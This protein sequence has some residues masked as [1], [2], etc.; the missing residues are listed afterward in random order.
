MSERLT[1]EQLRA[2]LDREPPTPHN[3]HCPVRDGRPCTCRGVQGQWRDFEPEQ[4]QVVPASENGFRAA[5]VPSAVRTEYFT[6]EALRKWGMN[7][8]AIDEYDCLDD[9][10]RAMGFVREPPQP[11]PSVR[12]NEVVHLAVGPFDAPY[13]KCRK[14]GERDVFTAHES[15]VTCAKCL[16]AS[17]NGPGTTNG[18]REVDGQGAQFDEALGPK[19]AT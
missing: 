1:P 9:A 2:W 18:N 14:A 3:D 8:S 12:P 7:P 5:K 13:A 10:M 6:R 16:Q 11:A 17:V 4:C 15:L 19:A